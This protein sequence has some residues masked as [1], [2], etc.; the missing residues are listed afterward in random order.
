MKNK[1]LM[2]RMGFAFSGLKIAIRTEKSI[3]FQLMC[4]GGVF[5]VLVVL[6]PEIY[7]WAIVI[8]VVAMVLAAEMFNTAIEAVCDFI[9][10]EYHEKI[11][12]IKDIA[13]AA[14]L[15]TSAGAL[16]VAL[17]L[18]YDSINLMLFF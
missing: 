5:F 4:A 18:L 6:Q 8:L 3:R 14:V 17:L 7:W 1:Q 13:A 9:Q 10:P 12:N 2:M 16:L 15:M 11:K